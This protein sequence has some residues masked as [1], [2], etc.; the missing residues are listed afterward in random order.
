M[1]PRVRCITDWSELRRIAA[2]WEDLARE[3]AEPNVFHE[4][5]MLLPALARLLPDAEKEKVRILLIQGDR[6]ELLGLLPLELRRRYKKL[7]L[8][9]L[10]VWQH[11]HCFLCTPLL[12]R[13]AVR[14]ALG[15]FHDW[16]SSEPGLPGL[17]VWNGIGGSGPVGNALRELVAERGWT[18]KEESFE[19]ALLVRR[20]GLSAQAHVDAVLSGGHRRDLR[21]LEKR[22]AELG[23]FSYHGSGM[24]GLAP[25]TAA[26]ALDRWI[27]EF[28]ELEKRGWKGREG[29]ALACREEDRTFFTDCV[30]GAFERGRLSTLDARLGGKMIASR[31][32]FHAGS[33]AAMASTA[34]SFKIAYDETYARYRPGLLLE[35]R[36]IHEVYGQALDRVDYCADPGHPM[37]DRLTEDRL[38]ISTL[39]VAT[40]SIPE[41]ALLALCSRLDPL[42]AIARSRRARK[43]R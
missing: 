39:A 30:R 18:Q 41:G 1:S 16:L 31:V 22:L 40:R 36:H 13:S 33:G 34:Y 17:M 37:L 20:S 26:G 21:R 43:T 15:A 28:L 19:R 38:R 7:P 29:T 8:A 3:A 10:R 14:E 24:A 25:D 12:R 27:E 4:S 5:W 23:E 9:H 32:N 2:E 35:V 11:R 6:G 42:L